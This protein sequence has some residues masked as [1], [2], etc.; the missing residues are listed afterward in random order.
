MLV[1]L[2]NPQPAFAK[3]S[4]KRQA[5]SPP[6]LPNKRPKLDEASP[7]KTPSPFVS[8]SPLAS[9]PFPPQTSSS[10]PSSLSPLSDASVSRSPSP[11]PDEAWAGVQK[12]PVTTENEQIT[13]TIPDAV[14]QPQVEDPGSPLKIK[15][16]VSLNKTGTQDEPK[17]ESSTVSLAERIKGMVKLRRYVTASALETAAKE[18][19]HK[20]DGYKKNWE[21]NRAKYAV[22]MT[23]TNLSSKRSLNLFLTNYLKSC[24]YYFKKAQLSEN[25]Q[26]LNEVCDLCEGVSRLAEYAINMGSK[27]NDNSTNYNTILFLLYDIPVP[28]LY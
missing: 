19:K 22:T 20:G 16:R 27:N 7:N 4:K 26:H 18:F 2:P 24:I 6:F 1:D 17:S 11:M 5:E 3:V 23:Q 8:S 10:H 12:S 15:L 21:S 13:P 9:S 14:K 28:L 25:R